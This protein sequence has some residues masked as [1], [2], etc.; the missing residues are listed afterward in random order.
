MRSFATLLLGALLVGRTASPCTIVS[1]RAADG[2]TWVGGNEDWAFDF[3][4]AMTVLP[5]DGKLLGAVVFSY[6]IGNFPQAGINESGLFFDFNTLSPTSTARYL[7]WD[8]KK[9]FPAGDRALVDHMIRTCSTVPQALELFGTYRTEGLLS[10]QLHL[11][12]REGRLAILNADGAETSRIGFQVSTNFN[13]CTK[14]ETAEAKSCWRYPI[15]ER[16]IRQRGAGLQTFRD[17]L[18]ATQQHVIASTVYSHVANLRTG[19]TWLTYAGDFE[20]PYRFNVAELLARGGRSV[21]MR[22]LFPRAPVVTVWEAFR[23]GGPEAAVRAFD[24]LRSS[25]LPKARAERLMLQVF[26]SCLLTTNDFAA[27]RVFFESWLAVGGADDP[28]VGYYRGLILL[29]SG[30]LE[31]ARTQLAAQ[32]ALEPRDEPGRL[33]RTSSEK[34]LARLEGRSP[35]ASTRFELK[36]HRD[37]TFVALRLPDRFPVTMPLF[38]TANGWAGAFAIPKGKLDYAFVVD[39]RTILDPANQASEIYEGEDGRYRMSVREIP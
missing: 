18:D 24:R 39:G 20:H 4:T 30:L 38:R 36:G 35:G 16:L 7:G 1:G 14:R 27:A 17:V 10:S 28:S 11:A 26:S 2:A 6:G 25:G 34:L 3:D 15:A 9:D 8:Q 32:I 13:V 31:A 19:D 29:S 21:L 22:S 23:A 5:R 37:A 33:V 12:D